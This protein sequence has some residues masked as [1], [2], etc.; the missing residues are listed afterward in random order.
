MVCIRD[1]VGGTI[2]FQFN[3]TS[4]VIKNAESMLEQWE[5]FTEVKARNGLKAII[6]REVGITNKQL[7]LKVCL[8]GTDRD[9]DLA[10]LMSVLEDN[11]FFYLDTESFQTRLDGTYAPNGR[12]QQKRDQHKRMVTID[13]D[14][15]EK[16][17]DT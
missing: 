12:G 4:K 13:F 3:N 2:L 16:E 8:V 1:E 10:T 17:D 6:K 7:H 9:T 15:I 14:L 11:E 5:F